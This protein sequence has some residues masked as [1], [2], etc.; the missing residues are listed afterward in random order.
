MANN[1]IA[2][3]IGKNRGRSRGST[4]RGGILPSEQRKRSRQDS[5]EEGRSVTAATNAPEPCLKRSRF[6]GVTGAGAAINSVLKSADPSSYRSKRKTTTKINASNEEMNIDESDTGANT[7]CID[8]ADQKTD[9]RLKSGVVLN[10]RRKVAAAKKGLLEALA[11]LVSGHRQKEGPLEKADT[12]R[13]AHFS[14]IQSLKR[15]KK[16]IQSPNE[17][18]TDSEAA[19]YL[20]ISKDSES[21][22]LKASPRLSLN[23]RH[24]CSKAGILSKDQILAST[25]HA[26]AEVKERGPDERPVRSTKSLSTERKDRGDMGP[27]TSARQQERK[28]RNKRQQKEK[29]SLRLALKGR[30]HYN[31][32]GVVDEEATRWALPSRKRA[33]GRQVYDKQGYDRSEGQHDDAKDGKGEQSNAGKGKRSGR[34]AGA[35]KRSTRSRAGDPRAAQ[36]SRLKSAPSKG[37]EASTTRRRHKNDKHD[38]SH[39]HS[40]RMFEE[41]KKEGRG[42][43]KEKRP[44]LEEESEADE[45]P[46]PRRH[47][48]PPLQTRS[49]TRVKRSSRLAR[50]DRRVYGKDGFRVVTQE[51]CAE[52]PTEARAGRKRMRR[53]RRAWVKGVVTVQAPEDILGQRAKRHLKALGD[54]LFTLKALSDRWA[55]TANVEADER[56]VPLRQTRTEAE[57]K[58]TTAKRQLRESMAQLLNLYKEEALEDSDWEAEE[59]TCAV[60]GGGEATDENDIAICDK[61]R[62][63]YHQDCH[64]PPLRPEDLGEEEDEWWCSRCELVYDRL[65]NAVLDAYGVE[66]ERARTFRRVQSL[67][68]DADDSKAEG[69]DHEESEEEDSDYVTEESEDEDEDEDSGS[70]DGSGEDEER[71]GGGSSDN[72]SRSAALSND[73]VGQKLRAVRKEEAPRK[74]QNNR[75]QDKESYARARSSSTGSYHSS[76]DED[77]DSDNSSYSSGDSFDS[78]FY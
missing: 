40:M 46:R 7:K 8:D 28:R 63:P 1:Y 45:R 74:C 37:A 66:E 19:Q 75:K 57:A 34:Q 59:A 12:R 54:N 29:H 52:L 21:A 5:S 26:G 56:H 48:F 44:P 15:P 39:A 78:D 6:M 2:G 49:R 67:L 70:E 77:F 50:K 32:E 71:G 30:R 58:L 61:C 24:R 36:D 47:S 14:S 31:A 51:S 13:S 72:G 73:K 27:S 60:C 17:A 4:P 20:P 16:P 76:E 25:L 33:L 43:K 23:P 68:E 53:K 38:Y 42:R 65:S 18:S 62:V 64:A 11:R 69:A 3:Q 55:G 41:G 35:S 9:D 22:A 10:M